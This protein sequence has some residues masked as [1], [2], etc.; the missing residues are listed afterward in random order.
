MCKGTLLDESINYKR[1]LTF[2]PLR[3]CDSRLRHHRRYSC[4]WNCAAVWTR[5]DAAATSD[6][7][8]APPSSNAWTCSW[9]SGNC[10][11]GSPCTTDNP[12]CRYYR[13]WICWERGAVARRSPGNA[14]PRFPCNGEICSPASCTCRSGNRGRRYTPPPDRRR[15]ARADTCN[16]SRDG[17]HSSGSP[18]RCDS[19]HRG[20]LSRSR[21]IRPPSRS[22]AADAPPS[23]CRPTFSSVF[24][25][26]KHSGRRRTFDQSTEPA[27][28]G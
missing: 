6:C 14:S 23:R 5:C 20:C 3:I 8:A 22:P 10:P 4:R 7:A 12:T 21:S 1:S 17:T 16:A 15:N 13:S 25:S 2:Y 11:W 26:M 27:K 18:C 19:R 24:S 9:L 28:H